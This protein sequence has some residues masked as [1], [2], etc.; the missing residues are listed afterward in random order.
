MGAVVAGSHIAEGLDSLVQ[1]AAAAL[2]VCHKT[3]VLD[4][5]RVHDHLL[6]CSCGC[7]REKSQLLQQGSLEALRFHS[8]RAKV[9]LYRVT[10]ADLVDG[11]E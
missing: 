7:Q 5:G 10:P 6:G 4:K 2:V 8:S 11:D 9:P 1:N 3:V